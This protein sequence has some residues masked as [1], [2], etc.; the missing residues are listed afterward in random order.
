MDD[1]LHF[2]QKIR[3]RVVA[4]EETILELTSLGLVDNPTAS[5]WR[6]HLGI[7]E[8]SLGDSLL[9]VAVVG[10]VKSGKSTLVNTLLGKD[11]LK[12]GA[13]IITAFV[14]RVLTEG[15]PGGWVELKSWSQV[16]DEL[17][18]TLRLLPICSEDFDESGALDIEKARDRDLLRVRLDQARAEKTRN[19]G[20]ID[21]SFL[22]LNGYLEGYNGIHAAMGETI[23]RL[24]FDERTIGGH[25]RF[26]GNESQAVYVRDMELRWPAPWLGSKVEL[27]DC[28]GSDSPNP[29]HYALLQQYLLKSN[30]ILYVIASRT[31]LREADFKLLDFIKTLRMFPQTFFVLNLDL[32]AHSHLDELNSAVERVRKELEWIVPDPQL[33]SFSSLYHLIEQLG[34]VASERERRRFNFWREEKSL[35]DFTG[36]G[37]VG[38]KERVSRRITEQRARVLFGSGLGRLGIVASGILDTIAAQKSLTSQ[39]LGSLKKCA[40]QLK[41]KQ[42]VLQG[43]FATLES[44]IAGLNDSLKK[45]S[46]E[47][48]DRYFHPEEGA[49]VKESLAMVEHYPIDA[50]YH[51]NLSDLRHLLRQL[52]HFYLDFRQSQ[53]RFIVE[54]VNL[55]VIEFAKNL[56]ASLQEQLASASHSFWAL[57][58]SALDEY[59]REMSQFQIDLG[60][61]SDIPDCRWSFPEANAP[62]TFSAFIDQGAVG[63]GVLLLKFG[64]GRFTRFFMGLTSRVGKTKDFLMRENQ[65]NETLRE[66]VSLLKSEAASELAFAFRSYRDK[67]KSEHLHRLID[68]GA[69]RLLE[70]FRARAETAWID[71]ASLIERSEVEGE[72]RQEMLEALLRTEASTRLIAEELSDLRCAINLEWLQS[73]EGANRKA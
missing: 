72:G 45:E 27:A 36:D 70:E 11:L 6:E 24:T 16:H 31:G 29:L 4:L 73:G 38:F 52:H 17:N 59:R 62:P 47:A 32:D 3:R 51:K 15:E 50:Q 30:F 43:T 34:D 28:Q 19:G 40:G 48:T 55:R 9:R 7:V 26:V 1:Y 22:L 37:F 25:Q 64:L 23:N 10:S 2:K 14:T 44:A 69:G 21:P 49:I 56:E 46:D 58:S 68:E 54:K 53:S 71:F 61:V 67:F 13:G 35:A 57:F 5:R 66:V 63:R 33:F 65:E 18:S 20:A 60:I 8:T 42:K 39:S 41:K 12:R